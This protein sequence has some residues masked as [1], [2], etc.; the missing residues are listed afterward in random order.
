MKI[1]RTLFDELVRWKDSR[2]RKPLILNGVRQCGKTWLLKEFGASEFNNVVYLNFERDAKLSSFFEGS[3]EP[4]AI[5]NNLSA[6]VGRNIMPGSTLLIF[7]EIQRCPRA[8]NSLKYFCEEA[9]EYAIASAGSLLG[10]SLA[11]K[12]GFLFRST[13]QI[14]ADY[15]ELPAFEEYDDLLEAIKKSL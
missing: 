15:P 1:E 9:P 8:L 13:E 10:I 4:S 12:E 14:K 3:Y 11:S 5:L 2:D 6:Y 7:D